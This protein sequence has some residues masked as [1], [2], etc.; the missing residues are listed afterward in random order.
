[1]ARKAGRISMVLQPLSGREA[2]VLGFGRAGGA[3]VELKDQDGT[4][5]I[6]LLG[7]EFQRTV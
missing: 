2:R 1:M 6:R 4:K 3:T 5:F 7:M